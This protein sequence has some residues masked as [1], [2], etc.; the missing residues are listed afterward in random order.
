[1]GDVASNVATMFQI[2]TSLTICWS[3]L[4]CG[5]QIRDAIQFYHENKTIE[6]IDARNSMLFII[7]AISAWSIVIACLGCI[8]WLNILLLSIDPLDANYTS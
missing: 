4:V 1:M 6:E 3:M 2:T 7:L 8:I 5:M